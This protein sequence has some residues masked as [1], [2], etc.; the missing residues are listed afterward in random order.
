MSL[1]SS[2][3]NGG[4]CENVVPKAV[5]GMILWQLLNFSG[6]NLRMPPGFEST[7]LVCPSER[8]R[9]RSDSF[10]LQPIEDA[11]GGFGWLGVGVA[12]G[13]MF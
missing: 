2:P 7:K 13:E 1:R 4:G 6:V 8:C 9:D 5:V 12:A 3:W 11:A 10:L